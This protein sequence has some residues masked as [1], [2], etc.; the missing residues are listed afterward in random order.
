VLLGQTQDLR[1]L[2]LVKGTHPAASE[3]EGYRCQ[4]NMLGG[5]GGIL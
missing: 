3:P 1:C 2:I 4:Q 5:R